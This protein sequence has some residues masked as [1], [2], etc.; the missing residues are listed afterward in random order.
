MHVLP[1]VIVFVQL[2]SCHEFEYDWRQ[3]HLSRFVQHTLNL[4]TWFPVSAGQTI[5][6]APPSDPK[7][8]DVGEA[9][10]TCGQ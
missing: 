2:S 6:P 10:P 1:C 5:S 8:L 9:E 4:V 7:G 3:D